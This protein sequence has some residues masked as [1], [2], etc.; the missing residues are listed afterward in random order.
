MG[1]RRWARRH[2]GR[3]DAGGA[4]GRRRWKAAATTPTKSRSTPA[5]PMSSPIYFKLSD[6]DKH[7]VYFGLSGGAPPPGSRIS[8]RRRQHQ[9]LFLRR[10]GWHQDSDLHRRQMVQGGRLRAAAGRDRPGHAARRGLRRRRPARRWPTSANFRWN[11]ER[12]DNTVHIRFFDFYGAANQV[13]FDLFLP[14]GDAPGRDGEPCSGPTPP[15]RNIATTASAA[16]G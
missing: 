14:A 7:N 3:G 11:P 4:A 10:R 1:D 13:I 15:P 5:R 9:S 8:A 6:L 2:S 16:C 12:P